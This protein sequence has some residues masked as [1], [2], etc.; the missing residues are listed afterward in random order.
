VELTK[1]DHAVGE[2]PTAAPERDGRSSRSRLGGWARENAAYVAVTLLV[3]VFWILAGD[4]FMSARNWT[5]I[6]EQVAVLTVLAVAQTFLITAGYID[7]SVG[8]VLGLTCF[9]AAWGAQSHGSIG[10]L[11]GVGL[12]LLIGVVNGLIFSRVRIPSFIVTLAMMVGIRAVLQIISNGRAVYLETGPGSGLGW[13]EQ[14]GRFPGILIVTLLVVGVCWL[15]YN[16]TVFGQDLKAMGGN[17]RV[18]ALFGVS[19]NRRRI[20]AFGLVGTLVGIAGIINLSRAGAAS[21]V[22]G[23]G[24]ELEAISAVVLGGTPLTG[25]YGSIAKTVVGATAL[26]VLGSGLTLTGVPPSWND[27]VRAALLIIAIGIALDRKKIGMVK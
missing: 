26:I 22:T 10:L 11:I 27:V 19:L 7:L 20:A 16:K 13:L 3:L 9:G 2:A 5:Y 25:G 14:I 21:P 6:A 1:S 18:V 23:T 12:G 17:E 15:V 8:S 4:N 24:M